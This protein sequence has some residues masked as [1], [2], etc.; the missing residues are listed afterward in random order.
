LPAP[1]P[2][3]TVE[4]VEK[5]ESPSSLIQAQVKV[6][7]IPVEEKSSSSSSSSSSSDEE[8]IK[9]QQVKTVNQC[10]LT[11]HGSIIYKLAPAMLVIINVSHKPTNFNLL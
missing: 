4:P 11:I 2:E 3:P 1:T 10:H 5:V 7:E 8:Q 9:D 6:K